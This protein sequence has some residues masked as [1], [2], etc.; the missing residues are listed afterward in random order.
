MVYFNIVIALYLK[1]L[2]NTLAGG[3]AG[4]GTCS[5]EFWAVSD[6]FSAAAFM[7]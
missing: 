1:A 5:S 2:G 6:D 7:I 4:F 3:G